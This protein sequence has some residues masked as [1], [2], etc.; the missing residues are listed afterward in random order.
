MTRRERYQPGPTD[1][2]AL[3]VGGSTDD[4]R[5]IRRSAVQAAAGHLQRREG[6]VAA[7]PAKVLREIA[8]DVDDGATSSSPREAWGDYVRPALSALDTVEELSAGRWR[9]V[10]PSDRADA[11]RL[12]STPDTGEPDVATLAAEESASER[13]T[14]ESVAAMTGLDENEVRRRRAADRDPDGP[15]ESAADRND[16]DHDRNRDAALASGAVDG[17]FSPSSTDATDREEDPDLMGS[18]RAIRN[19]VTF[20]QSAVDDARSRGRNQDGEASLSASD[21]GNAATGPPC[22]RC[23]EAA[24]NAVDAPLMDSRFSLEDEL[25]HDC[26]KAVAFDRERRDV[27]GRNE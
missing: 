19:S 25:C 23:G 7:V 21:D 10:G 20:P 1:V 8:F 6:E 26:F 3:S 5:E 22:A 13:K 18:D 15:A 2:T 14:V 9:Y 27:H 24:P 4:E 11:T 16:P 12:A 17:G